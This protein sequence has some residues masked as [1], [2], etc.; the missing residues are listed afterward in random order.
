MELPVRRG[1]L[2]N[3][4]APYK[5]SPLSKHIVG[6]WYISHKT[7][8]IPYLSILDLLGPLSISVREINFKFDLF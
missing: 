1:S 6:Q 5:F 7:H 2:Y 3:Y 4:I 8:V